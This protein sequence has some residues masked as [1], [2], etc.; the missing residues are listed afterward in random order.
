MYARSLTALPSP[1]ATATL[2]GKV[3][4]MS[5]PLQDLLLPAV[6]VAMYTKGG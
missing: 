5:D 4:T 3:R 6:I 2:L 1:D